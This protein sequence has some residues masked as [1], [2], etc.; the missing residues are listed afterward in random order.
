MIGFQLIIKVS[1][2]TFSGRNLHKRLIFNTL[3]PTARGEQFELYR[4]GITI[5]E[6]KRRGRSWRFKSFFVSLSVVTT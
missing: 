5:W 2:R 1:T 6:V 4:I 3:S